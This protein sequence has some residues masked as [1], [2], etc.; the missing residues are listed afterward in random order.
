MSICMNYT[1]KTLIATSKVIDNY[2][3]SV[4]WKL[5]IYVVYVFDYIFLL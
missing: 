1:Y 3:Y 4:V 2:L 5:C